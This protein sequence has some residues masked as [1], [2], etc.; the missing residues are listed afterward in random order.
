MSTP[1]PSAPKIATAAVIRALDGLDPSSKLAVLALAE[2][3]IRRHQRANRYDMDPAVDPHVGQA[4]V[5]ERQRTAR[6]TVTLRHGP[7]VGYETSR[8]TGLV[9]LGEFAQWVRRCGA[10]ALG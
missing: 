7:M 6:R 9:T 2:R 3:V 10:R 1:Q 5:P 8:T 4:W